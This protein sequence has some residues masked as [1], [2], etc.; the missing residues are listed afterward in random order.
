MLFHC[1]KIDL[2]LYEI[3]I[4]TPN[5]NNKYKIKHDAVFSCLRPA[6]LAT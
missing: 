3:M 6:C 4:H 1:G 2:L 5:A